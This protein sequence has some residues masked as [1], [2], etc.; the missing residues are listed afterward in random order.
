MRYEKDDNGIEYSFPPPSSVLCER[1]LEIVDHLNK[2]IE[3][4]HKVEL[5]NDHTVETF[6]KELKL[7][8]EENSKLKKMNQEIEDRYNTDTTALLELCEEL[9]KELLTFDPMFKGPTKYT[10]MTTNLKR[11]SIKEKTIKEK[12]QS[13]LKEEPKKTVEN[14]EYIKIIEQ[15]TKERDQWKQKA[16][17]LQVDCLAKTKTTED[18]VKL[19]KY[20]KELKALKDYIQQLETQHPIVLKQQQT[21]PDLTTTQQQVDDQNDEKRLQN[22]DDQWRRM[23]Q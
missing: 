21:E 9:R 17:E 16:L 10:E 18:N 7:L 11:K 5:R 3:L 2:T 6:Q 22:V 13:N 1:G 23:T 14:E 4:K 19:E 8:I 12:E 20:E 15:L